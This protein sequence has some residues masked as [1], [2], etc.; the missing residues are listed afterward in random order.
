[1]TSNTPLHGQVQTAA[2]RSPDRHLDLQRRLIRIPR[3]SARNT[4]A[5][6]WDRVTFKELWRLAKNAPEAGIHVQDMII[7][8]RIADAGKVTADRLSEP[9]IQDPWFKE[10][11]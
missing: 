7:Y 10:I 2:G 3:V 9:L 5:A 8:S 1:M 11:S 6:E 4:P